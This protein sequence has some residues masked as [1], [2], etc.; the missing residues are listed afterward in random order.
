M[1]YYPIAIEL[2]GRKCLVVGGG[3]VALRKAQALVDA[4]ASVT[5]IAP[6]ADP[7]LHPME[8]VTVLRRQY[9]AGDASGYSLVFAATDDRTV[10][11]TVAQDAVRSGALVNVVDEGEL[12][13]FI[14]PSVVRRGDLL[15]AVT[16]SGKSPALSRK[17][18][19]DLEQRYGPEYAEFVDLLG[20]L[21]DCVKAAHPSQE[22]REAVFR[23]LLDSGI[24]ELLREGNVQG[25]REKA[26]RCI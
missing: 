18:R 7:R 6:E 17:I 19:L 3:E 12:C 26:L 16:T 2:T 14:A 13:S 11:A 8:G 10:N 5:V 21:R 9:E 24:L 1:A 22:E 20:S 4:G 15:I 25:A 23:R